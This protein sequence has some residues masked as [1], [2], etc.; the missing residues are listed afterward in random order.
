MQ[1]EGVS[2]CYT[3]ESIPNESDLNIHQNPYCIPNKQL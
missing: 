2:L 3:D 1:S